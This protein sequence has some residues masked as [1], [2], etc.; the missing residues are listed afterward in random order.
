MDDRLK[1][2]LTDNLHLV[3]NYEFE[4]LY[5]RIKTELVSDLTEVL[6]SL[7][8]NPLEY[9][10]YV[11]HGFCMHHEM[12]SFNIPTTVTLIDRYAFYACTELKHITIPNSV[13]LIKGHAFQGCTKLTTITIPSNVVEIGKYAFSDCMAL[14][15]VNIENGVRII[16]RA[17][18]SECSKLESIT[19]PESIDEI[20]TEAFSDCF[21]LTDIN[22]MGTKKKWLSIT[23]EDWDYNTN[24]Y[25]VHCIDGDIIK[26]RKDDL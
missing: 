13:T 6:L 24:Y 26:D 15:N 18:F 22:Y 2:F 16:G 17:S 23:K 1:E 7:D 21:R 5:Y 25:T 12:E 9:M 3:D 4:D 10:S 8:I 20:S 11:P 19:I 14:T